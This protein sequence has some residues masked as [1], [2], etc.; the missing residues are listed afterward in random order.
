MKRDLEKKNVF[1][2]F[3]VLNFE[4]GV[5]EGEREGK[6]KNIKKLLAAIFRICIVGR[7]AATQNSLRSDHFY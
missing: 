1:G 6:L 5:L 7:V 4:P 2:S 3:Y